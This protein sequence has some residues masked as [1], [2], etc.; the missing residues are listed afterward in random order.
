MDF[1]TFWW[2]QWE[3]ISMSMYY[4]TYTSDSPDQWITVDPL[5][6]GLQKE[7]VESYQVNEP[8]IM[9]E[10]LHFVPS[11]SNSPFFIFLFGFF[12]F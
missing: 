1:S 6:L 3:M 11:Y 9:F 10:H 7:H 5:H 4:V 8:A 2:I 12:S